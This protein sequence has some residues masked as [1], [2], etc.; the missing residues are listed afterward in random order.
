MRSSN[1]R[2]VTTQVV[3]RRVEELSSQDKITQAV[4]HLEREDYKQVIIS[5]R[6]GY[7][8]ND[9]KVIE[10]LERVAHAFTEV[11]LEEPDGKPRDLTNS[12]LN[13][14]RIYELLYQVPREEVEK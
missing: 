4:Q 12:K 8:I 11:P 14:I 3:E 2:Y 5:W 1:N 9:F 10:T 6:C 13:R 7:I